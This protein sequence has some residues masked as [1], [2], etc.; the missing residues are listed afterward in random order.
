MRYL[1][2]FVIAVAIMSAGCNK[3]AEPAPAATTD[4]PRDRDMGTG[5]VAPLGSPSPSMG[6]PVTPMP[7]PVA[8]EP[9]SPAPTGKST[10]YTVQKGD[11]WMSIA[12]KVL[13]NEHRWKEIKDLNPDVTGPLKVGQ[14]VKVPAK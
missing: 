8:V 11:G 3:P 10:T 4:L 7:A 2:M 5:T 1:S 12:R 9:V 14:V 13:N 6:A